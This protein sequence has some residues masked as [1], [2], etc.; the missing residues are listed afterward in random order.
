MKRSTRHRRQAEP[1]WPRVV[2]RKWLNIRNKDSDFSADSESEVASD[3]DSD[4]DFYELP[5]ESR[6]KDEKSC[7]EV[8]I[9]ANEA[10]PRLRRRKSETFRAQYIST[11]EI[12]VCVGTWNVGG[13]VPPD[14]LDLDGWLD[15][16]EPADIYVLGFQEIIPLNAGNIF[17]AEDSRPILKWENIIR[18]SLDKIPSGNKFKSFSDPPSPSRFKPSEDIH[19]IEEEIVLESDSEGEEEIVP[20]NEEFNEF[21]EVKNGNVSGSDMVVDADVPTFNGNREDGYKRQFSLPKRINELDC[22]IPEECEG[23]AEELSTQYGKK[24]TK[25]LSVTEKI[26]L[27][28]PEQPL[29]ILPQHI[30]DRPNCI[31]SMKSFK[32]SK[33]FRRYSSFNSTANGQNRMQP[34][35][36]MLAEIDLESLIK[37]KRRSPYVRIISK[38]MVDIFL[39]IWV[40]RGLRKHIQNLNVSTVGVGVMG[41]I[42]NKLR[43]ELKKGRAFD[44]WAE[45][46]LNFPPTYK[47]DIN[48][49]KYH[50]EDPRSGRRTPAW[51]DRILSYG[52]GMRLLNYR[53]SD[54]RTSDH[55][56][57]TASYMVEVEIFCPKKL[58]R[59][60]TFTDAE[61]D[62]E[63]IV[64]DTEI[65]SGISRLM[66]E[67]NASLW[68]H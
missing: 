53:R 35:I 17:G 19:D 10:V 3:S 24:L 39:T 31:K 32:A 23:N 29:D 46:V 60:L 16:G 21:V 7:G 64:T 2:M 20:I 63:E 34:D 37:Q 54:L 4:Q 42:G 50:G 15:I 30:L 55:R 41:Y 67:Q 25:T 47:Y 13:K 68:R 5:R 1:F 52:K 11:K 8:E 40:R 22:S 44:G 14:D 33:S 12:R 57:V 49:D 6:F 61:I 28:W 43:K 56:P 48:S 26:G 66:I 59:A 38:Q 9:D 51:C 18:E 62:K 36:A 45:G 58:Q 27:C 65:E